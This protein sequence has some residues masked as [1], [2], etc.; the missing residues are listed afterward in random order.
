MNGGY[1]RYLEWAQTAGERAGAAIMSHYRTAGPVDL[2]S[3][4][5]PVTPADRAAHEAIMT[6]LAQA[7]PDV[8]VASEE[9]DEIS[10]DRYWSVDPLDGTKEYVA[11]T[12]AFVV[13]VALVEDGRPVVGVIFVPVTGECYFALKG[14]GAF[15]KTQGRVQ[16]LTGRTFAG[17]PV[18]VVGSARHGTE[19]VSKLCEALACGEGGIER[20]AL[21]SA[22][23]FGWLAEGRADLY[24]RLGPTHTWD[25]AAG[26]CLVEESGGAVWVAGREPLVYHHARQLNPSFVAVADARFAWPDLLL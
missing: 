18:R 23:K 25:T 11:R 9:G 15:K 17:G 5:S 12:D 26:Q 24:P 8:P 21:G 10:G 2:K 1:R 16:R 20:T 13:N 6:V 7:T 14:E 3:D 4:G 19:A 22:W